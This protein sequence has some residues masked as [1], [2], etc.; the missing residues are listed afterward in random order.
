[1]DPNLQTIKNAN[2]KLIHK[3]KLRRPILQ[4]KDYLTHIL[5]EYKQQMIDHELDEFVDHLKS[6]KR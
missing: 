4:A 2:I 5:T 1:M 3:G 6:E